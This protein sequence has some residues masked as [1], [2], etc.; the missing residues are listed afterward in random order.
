MS[1]LKI[2]LSTEIKN[3]ILKPLPFE[4]VGGISCF[5]GKDCQPV[6]LTPLLESGRVSF[7]LRASPGTFS[8]HRFACEG[9]VT[10]HGT[11]GVPKTLLIPAGA[12]SGQGFAQK[13]CLVRSSLSP[14]LDAGQSLALVNRVASHPSPA[15]TAAPPGLCPTSGLLR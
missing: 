13:R 9:R 5:Y 3:S 7:R 14:S 12:P 4:K 6:L 11:R 1:F 2:V 15:G 10:R 8:R